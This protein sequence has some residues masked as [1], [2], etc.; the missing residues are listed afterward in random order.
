MNKIKLTIALL[1]MFI[2][3]AFAAPVG[4]RF[5][6]QGQLQVSNNAAN[7]MYDLHFSLWDNVSGMGQLGSDLI[8][9]DVDVVNGL[10]SVELNFGDLPFDGGDVFLEIRVREGVSTGS[11]TFISPRQRI[12]ATPYATQAEFLAANGATTGQILQFNGTN[13][14][15]ANVGNGTSPWTPGFGGTQYIGDV[16]I[17]D[18]VASAGDTLQILSEVDKSPLRILVGGV[19][20]RFRVS[21]NGGTG[22]GAN[23]SD[24]QIP[25]NG[26]RVSGDTAIGSTTSSAKLT[27]SGAVGQDPIR[28]RVN[29]TTKFVVQANGGTNIGGGSTVAPENGLDV[30]GGVVLGGAD[31]V[32][33]VSLNIASPAGTRPLAASVNGI[34]ALQVADNGGVRI[35]NGQVGAFPPPG[36]GLAVGGETILSAKTTINDDLIVKFDAKHSRTDS[37]GFV[38]AGVEFSCGHSGT[39]R[40]N[41]FNNINTDE[42]TVQNGVV[43]GYCQVKLPF[44]YADLYLQTTIETNSGPIIVGGCDKT[45]SGVGGSELIVCRLYDIENNTNIVTA[46]RVTLLI[47]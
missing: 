40:K 6:Y 1:T 7:G 42:I 8:L 4:S 22:V 12:N 38:K 11:F 23:Y 2:S 24:G 29:G 13:W 27:L 37:Y 32:S 43:F 3:S 17:G 16:V 15:A 14:A 5:S 21:K 9:E 31:P 20:T 19:G 41:Y 45:L 44:S 33:G 34:L 10:F 30:E 18:L 39:I 47:F 36:S 28:V 46:N 25:D 35:G 26:L